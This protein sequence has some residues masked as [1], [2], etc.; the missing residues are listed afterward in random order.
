MFLCLYC[1]SS[2]IPER[3]IVLLVHEGTWFSSQFLCCWRKF[4][5]PPPVSLHTRGVCPKPLHVEKPDPGFGGFLRFWWSKIWGG[6]PSRSDIESWGARR[7]SNTSQSTPGRNTSSAARFLI[8]ADFRFPM[9]D[10]GI[11]DFGRSRIS[12]NP[13][14]QKSDIRNRKSSSMRNRAALL[15]LGQGVH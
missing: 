12:K 13:K 14:I 4:T 15:V 8:V 7:A 3:F 10:F 2:S 6:I 9:P 1:I 5:S 11:L